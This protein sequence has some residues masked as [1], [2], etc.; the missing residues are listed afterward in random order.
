MKPLLLDCF[1]GAGG[2]GYGYKLA[3]FHV[4]GIDIEPQPRYAG[5][6]FIQADALEFIARHGHEFDVIHTSP[7][8]QGYSQMNHLIKGEYPMLIGEVRDVL[9]STGKPFVIENV[10][11]APLENPIMLCGT[12]FG[13]RVIR[14]RIFET[15]PPIWFAPFT[16]QHWLKCQKQGRK[17]DPDRHFITVTGNFSGQDYARRAMGIDWMS[18]AELSQAIPPAYTKWLGERLMDLLTVRV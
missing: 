9:R 11:G 17:P 2:A 15:S 18:R 3:G 7:P 5:D 12:M 6:K 1:S 13:L 16:C 14:H 10:I 8:C 4:T